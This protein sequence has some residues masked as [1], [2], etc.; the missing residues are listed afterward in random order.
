MR[1]CRNHVIKIELKTTFLAV[2]KGASSIEEL[3][4][5]R[6]KYAIQN[7]DEFRKAEEFVTNRGH[8]IGYYLSRAKLFI[9]NKIEFL[10]PG[11]SIDTAA[12]ESKGFGRTYILICGRDNDLLKPSQL[13]TET[14]AFFVELAKSSLNSA[15]HIATKDEVKPRFFFVDGRMHA[16]LPFEDARHLAVHYYRGNYVQSKDYF[17][18]YS[19]IP[20]VGKYELVDNGGYEDILIAT[21]FGWFQ[22][23]AILASYM[24]VTI[25]EDD[26]RYTVEIVTSVGTV[27]NK[28]RLNEPFSEMTADG[29]TADSVVVREGTSLIHV[30]TLQNPGSQSPKRHTIRTFTKKE[31]AVHLTANGA[32]ATRLFNR[33]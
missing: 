6:S 19:T 20:I 8:G 28:F 21:D 24:T 13:Y 15:V 4:K 10:E 14:V 2:Q 16:N 17:G 25:S 12:Q 3:E 27:T 31:M 18:D 23:K 7:C 26:G 11:K 1:P 5:L 32:R 30:Q 29:L 22:R 9:A 33:V